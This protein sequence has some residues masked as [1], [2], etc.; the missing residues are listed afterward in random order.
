MTSLLNLATT[1]ELKP[2]FTTT[3]EGNQVP[4]Q[5]FD[6]DVWLDCTIPYAFNNVKR[7]VLQCGRLKARGLHPDAA[8]RDLHDIV[9]CLPLTCEQYLLAQ[10]KIFVFVRVECVVG[11]DLQLKLPLHD[12]SRAT[13]HAEATF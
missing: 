8:I 4:Y 3:R 2:E 1:F 7:V 13:S 12:L 6:L 5:P 11:E 10:L 9:A